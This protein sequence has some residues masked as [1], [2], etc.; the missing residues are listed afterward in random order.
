MANASSNFKEAS[1]LIPL[2][3]SIPSHN[4]GEAMAVED[5]SFPTID[6]II[7]C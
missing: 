5:E 7:P 3:V 1:D 6:E 4:E 2:T